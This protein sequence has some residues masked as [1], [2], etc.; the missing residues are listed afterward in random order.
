M[1]TFLL[2]LLPFLATGCVG[3][4]ADECEGDACDG[5]GPPPESLAERCSGSPCGWVDDPLTGAPALCEASFSCEE[6]Q[7]CRAD[8]SP[9][10]CTPSCERVADGDDD[11]C[12]T[13]CETY[14]ERWTQLAIPEG[15]AVP[16]PRGSFG[17]ALVP[18]DEPAV[19]LVSGRTLDDVRQ[20]IVYGETWLLTVGDEPVWRSLGAA[21]L[22][23]PRHGAPL[24]F[25]P[26]LGRS[27][28]FSGFTDEAELALDDALWAFDRTAEGGAWT[29]LE[30]AGADGAPA[31]RGAHCAVHDPVRDELVVF[32]GSA[33]PS[34]TDV[35]PVHGETW[36][37]TR[38]GAAVTWVKKAP[39]TSPPPLLRPAC[40]WDGTGVLLFGGADRDA[41]LFDRTWR[42]DG[43]TWTEL[44]GGADRPSARH[45]AAA[46]W[47]E[48]RD[49]VVLEGG[50][51]RGDAGA[52]DTLD[53][54]WAWRATADGGTWRQ[55]EQPW[56]GERRAAG[57]VAVPPGSFAGPHMPQA[58]G[59]L[60]FGGTR[61]DF[62][63]RNDLWRL[64]PPLEGP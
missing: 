63:T 31:P 2:V 11:G 43:T 25:H 45:S 53:D 10:C 48:A 58:G 44:G 24:V 7:K 36:V 59:L 62:A 23:R 55:L 29:R 52:E 9:G 20:P 42:W 41:N 14:V 37:L 50:F 17:F 19:V 8:G 49:R 28:L 15:A 13:P 3:L 57:F 38:A 64:A 30:P 60:L 32:G 4:F 26:G 12:G 61:S 27:L 46:A 5:G 54:V 22:D 21:G 51:G 34:R 1:R 40:A 33:S 56:P 6:G 16:E 39:A 35:L 47:D 18:G